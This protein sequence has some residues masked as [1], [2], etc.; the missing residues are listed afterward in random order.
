MSS[1]VSA[2]G[3]TRLAGSLSDINDAKLADALTGLPNRLL[4]VDV[5]GPA[6]KRLERRRDYVFALLV[7]GLDRFK[8]LNQSLGV[9]GADRLLVAVAQRLQS[10]LPQAVD[11]TTADRL[12]ASQPWLEQISCAG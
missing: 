4:F 12:I 8:E 11:L 3:I 1:A 2:G 5:L 9:L 10:S 6:I 7:L